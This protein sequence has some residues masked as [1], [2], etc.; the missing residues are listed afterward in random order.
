MRKDFSHFDD[1]MNFVIDDK[2]ASGAMSASRN[3]FPVRFVLFDN[4]QDSYLFVSKVQEA[5]CMFKSVNDWMDVDYPD[6]MLTYSEL[7]DGILSYASNYNADCIITPFSELAR[8]YNNE[9][10]AKEFDALVKTIKGIENSST[11]VANNRRIYIPIVGLEG[12]MSLFEND[13]QCTIW[14]L[15]NNDKNLTYNLLLTNNTFFGLKDLSQFN[16]ALN[17][18]EWLDVWKAQPAVKPMILCSSSVPQLTIT[19]GTGLSIVPGLKF[20]LLIIFS[21]V[22]LMFYGIHPAIRFQIPYIRL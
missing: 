5:G 6:T 15:K 1:L 17:V 2:A 19:A 12:K 8:F 11:A 9:N 10:S 16:V 20:N 21:S 18:N 22:F 14:Y 3:R 4:F 13:T 7:S